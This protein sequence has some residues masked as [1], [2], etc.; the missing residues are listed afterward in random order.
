M[1]RPILVDSCWYIH[2][3]R[4]GHDPL[5]ALSF[6]AETRDIATCGLIQAEVGRGLRHR[7]WLEKYQRAWSVMLF[8]DSSPKRWEETL[9]L[10][11]NLDR[12]GVN[13][14]IQ[15]IHIAACALHAGAVVLTYDRHFQAI[16]G[17]DETDRIL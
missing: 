6:L 7:R 8:P 14:P 5:R 9:E 3:A 11:S 17:L 12:Q 16:P 10:A 2:Q 13:L 4:N 15:D 1:S